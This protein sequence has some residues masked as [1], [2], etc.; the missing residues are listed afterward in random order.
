MVDY[1]KISQ[2]ISFQADGIWPL[3]QFSNTGNTR[4]AE[5]LKDILR[6]LLDKGPVKHVH[7]KNITGI[8]TEVFR[9]GTRGW[10]YPWVITA[11]NR[12]LDGG[13]S[14]LDCGCGVNGFPVILNNLGYKVTGLDYFVGKKFKVDGYGLPDSYIKKHSETVNFLNGGMEAIPSGDNMFD[15]ATCISVM[16]HV[17]IAYKSDPSFH[18]KCLAEMVRVL[19]PG[20]LLIC[21]YDTLL[22]H[23]VNFA[24]LPGWGKEGWSYLTDI[25]YLE[26]IGMS[27]LSDE[28]I[29]TFET[30]LSDPDSFFIPPDFYFSFGYGSGFEK[31]RTY[32]RLTSVGF[33]LKKRSDSQV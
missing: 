24:N 26:S 30:I 21:T 20:G 12:N 28:K 27:K 14:V 5:K 4:L 22:D 9:M 33:I 32:Q 11:L 31:Y 2:M 6:I 15:A 17:V 18:L 29:P 23:E 8:P 7:R 16:E 1:A 13:A 19:K 25:E 10:E 3:N